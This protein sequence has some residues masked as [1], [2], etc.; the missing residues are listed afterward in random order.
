[1]GATK[2]SD[3]SF[4]VKAV[5][6]SAVVQPTKAAEKQGW[7]FFTIPSPPDDYPNLKTVEVAFS[8]QTATVDAVSVYIANIQ[9]WS[10]S[11][12]QQTSTFDTDVSSVSASFDK[13]GIAVAV[14]LTFENLNSKINFQSVAVEFN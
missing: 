6:G 13:K 8:S 1:M 12:L 5:G 2:D 14:Q 7:V 10:Q 11:N 3:S 9:K 4:V